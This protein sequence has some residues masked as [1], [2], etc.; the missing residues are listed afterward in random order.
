MVFFFFFFLTYVSGKTEYVG[1]TI[2]IMPEID[3]DCFNIKDMHIMRENI[4]VINIAA[5]HFQIP[6]LPLDD[7][8]CSLASNSDYWNL[9]DSLSITPKKCIHVYAE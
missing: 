6:G 3:S 1:G 4:G 2:D 8:L 9:F 7:G 5:L